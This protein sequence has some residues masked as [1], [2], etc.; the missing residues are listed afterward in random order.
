MHPGAVESEM[1]GIWRQEGFFG[2]GRRRL[3]AGIALILAV[4]FWL[5]AGGCGG[6]KAAGDGGGDKPKP[7]VPDTAI[8]G[9]PQWTY[10]SNAVVLRLKA[11]ATLNLYQGSAHTL[12]L[13]VYQLKD[14][15]AYN[16]LAKSTDGLVKL[17]ACQRFGDSVAGVQRV[18]VQPGT[19]RKIE[20]DRAEG[21][22]YVAVA[23]GY[24]ELDPNNASKLMKIP[25]DVVNQGW[26]F[27]D[28]Y[29][30]PGKLDVGLY[31]G[32]RGIQ[33]LGSY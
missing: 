14:P 19:E 18:I 8:P 22:K 28:K 11:D 30:L 10:G 33:E 32:P 21:A 20:M 7:E 26:V 6:K 31:L 13:C 25:V 29:Q 4:L 17:L 16:E 15:N 9:A 12:V 23:A 27:K 24:F 3:A 2:S 1:V 5:A